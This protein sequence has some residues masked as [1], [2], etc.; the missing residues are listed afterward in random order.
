MS[1]HGSVGCRESRRKRRPDH[2]HHETTLVLCFEKN[3][4]IQALEKTQLLLHV[5]LDCVEGVTHDYNRHGNPTLFAVLDIATGAVIVECGTS[6]RLQELLSFLRRIDREV[7]QE[8]DL[9]LI[10][11][12]FC[13]HKHA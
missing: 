3:T 9:H 7:V 8:L 11:G 13:T 12:N 5:G 1:T 2:N 10:A 4:K 6:H